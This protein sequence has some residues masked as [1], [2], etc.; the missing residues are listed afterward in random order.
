MVGRVHEVILEN[1]KSYEGRVR[2]GP[3]KRFTCVVGPNG[4]GKSN[5]MDAISFVLG[6]QTRHLRSDRLQELVHRKENEEGPSRRPC[7][8]ELVLVHEDSEGAEEAQQTVFKRVI[9]PSSAARYQVNSQAVSAEEYMKKL[10]AINILSRARNF[11]V[12]QGD[13]EAAVHRQ[14]R[15]LTNFFEQVSGSLALRDEYERLAAEKAQKEEAA[16][17]LYARKRT[18]LTEKRRMTEQKDEAEKFQALYAQR[19]KIQVEFFLFRLNCGAAAL[20]ELQ[21]KLEEQT[22]LR[23]AAALELER[24]Q[25]DLEAA[26]RQR[27]QARLATTK[28]ERVMASSKSKLQKISPEQMQ[29]KNQ[30]EVARNRCEDLKQCAERDSKRRKKLESEAAALR[31][32]KEQLEA[33]LAALAEKVAKQLPFTAE[34][35]IEF[36]QAKLLADRFAAESTQQAKELDSRVR[37]LAGERARTEREAREAAAK[38]SQL[39]QRIEDLHQAK[40]QAEAA[41]AKDVGMAK[42]AMSQL[43]ELGTTNQGHV[44][45]RERL[46]AERQRVVREIQDITA[47]ERQI[48]HEQRLAQVSQQLSQS[49]QGVH[50]RVVELCEP[51]QRGFRVAVN[52]ALGGYMDAII[53]NT[54]YGA[55]QCVQHLKERMLDP[56]TFLPLDNLRA[57]PPDQRLLQAL[58]GKHTLR[59]ALNCLNFSEQLSKAFEFMLGD[60]V[61]ADTMEEG[62]RFVFGELRERGLGCRIVTLDGETISRDG[63]LAVS[64]EAARQGATRFDFAALQSTK[65][66]LEAIDARLYELHSLDGGTSAA[67]LQDHVRRLDARARESELLVSRVQGELGARQE[68]LQATEAALARLGPEAERLLQ[69]ESARRGEQRRLESSIGDMVKGHFAKLSQEMGVED[70]RRVEAEFRREKEASKFREGEVAQQLAGLKAELSMIQ[71]SLQESASQK[72]AEKIQSSEE[73][74]ESLKLKQAE[75]TQEIEA[76]NE[77]MQKLNEAVEETR[78]AERQKEQVTTKCRRDLRSLQEKAAEA[79]RLA[80]GLEGEVRSLQEAKVDLLRQSI[81]EDVELPVLSRKAL[82]DLAAPPAGPE[83][84]LS[85]ADVEVDLSALSEDRRAVTSGPAVKLLEKEYREEI[86]RLELELEQ[87]QPNLKA[88]EQLQGASAQVLDATHEAVAARKGIEAVVTRFEAVRRARRERFL[89]CFQNVQQEI[90]GVYKRLTGGAPG[91]ASEGGSAF[92]DL[93]D[94]EDPYNGG[95][96][97]TAMP[98]AKRFRDISLLSGGEKTLAAMALLFALQAFQRPPF[99]VLDEIDASLDMR[100]VQ[101]LARYLEHSECQAIVISQKDKLFARSEALVGVSKDKRAE[102][103]VVLT[104]DLLRLRAPRAAPIPPALLPLPPPVL[105]CGGG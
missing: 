46:Q 1:F 95:I 102:T 76:A 34:Q 16:R 82:Q 62:R 14:G 56:V 10:E 25:R 24:V 11:L 22:A 23:A 12:F 28:A 15:E 75:L 38:K 49:I 41:L 88:M 87:L 26:D 98:P 89:Q 3:F 51:T 81:L 18:A 99:L 54:A 97:F 13:V 64:S 80:A 2:I 8:V 94:L 45:E 67:S 57:P 39:V 105:A 35:K 77:E 70:I 36:D 73:E 32:K 19:R 17:L 91:D 66:R 69:E 100:N 42:K 44:Q 71:K 21:R 61:I 92:L 63:N 52:V 86:Q 104:M 47:T 60:V 65:T 40:N 101:A 90:D 9:Q 68:E 20:Q 96:K 103:S 31:G 83:G 7:S 43:Q 72:L 33:E 53:T 48:Q 58:N 79:E 74:I 4:A 78:A 5:L 93:E 27:A 85:A 29:V 59:L 55:R 6:V 50:G 37:H 30:L 84:A